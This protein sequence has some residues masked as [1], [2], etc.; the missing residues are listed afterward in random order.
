MN[1]G[2]FSVLF[3]L[4]CG[5]GA[6]SGS[7]SDSGSVGASAA[8]GCDWFGSYC[9]DFVGASWDAASAEAQCDI[10]SSDA[11]SEGAPSATFVAAGCASGATAECTG[12]DGVPGDPDSDFIIYYYDDPP[13]AFAE[14][15]C[16]AGGGTYTLY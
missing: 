13:M 14:D 6:G 8:G 1:L 15:G 10:F 3:G 4:A 16:T 12:F 7:G 11:V 2:L 9:Y 5:G